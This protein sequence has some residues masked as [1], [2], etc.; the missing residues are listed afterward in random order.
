[1]IGAFKF[2]FYKKELSHYYPF[3]NQLIATKF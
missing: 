1:M 2:D 3:P